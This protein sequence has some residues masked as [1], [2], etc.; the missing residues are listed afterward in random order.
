VNA[1]FLGSHSLR[2]SRVLWPPNSFALFRSRVKVLLLALSSGGIIFFKWAGYF[3]LGGAGFM[4]QIV[5]GQGAVAVKGPAQ[6]AHAPDLLP[7][8]FS[9]LVCWQKHFLL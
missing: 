8:Y 6:Q 4:G 3:K 5:V 9:K 2:V 7:L 1:R